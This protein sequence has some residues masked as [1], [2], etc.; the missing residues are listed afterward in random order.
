MREKFKFSIKFSGTQTAS[1]PGTASLGWLADALVPC[2][3]L[4]TETI[5]S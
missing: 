3:L 5:S 1:S 2:F 4:G